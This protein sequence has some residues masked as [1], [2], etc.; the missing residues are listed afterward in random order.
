MRTTDDLRI[1]EIKELST[2]AEVMREF[3][4]SNASTPRPPC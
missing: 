4:R 2:P 1:R 3:P